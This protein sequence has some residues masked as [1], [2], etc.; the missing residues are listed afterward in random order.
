[1]KI[2]VKAEIKIPMTPNFLRMADGSYI[3]LEAI[4]DTGIKEIGR[5]WTKEMLEKAKQRRLKA[6]SER[7]DNG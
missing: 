7:T 2:S 1:M 6:R 3:P 4:T 5:L